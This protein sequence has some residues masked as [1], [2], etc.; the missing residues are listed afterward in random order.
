MTPHPAD[1]HTGHV[2]ARRG[3]KEY[4]L[5]RLD[6]RSRLEVKNARSTARPADGSERTNRRDA[7]DG[8]RSQ[9]R[10]EGTTGG[11]SRRLRG[12][13]GHEKRSAGDTHHV[14]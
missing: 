3:W 2:S 6:G 13:S 12:D 4:L 14:V 8:A 9:A 5:V 1:P 10:C 7:A 11:K